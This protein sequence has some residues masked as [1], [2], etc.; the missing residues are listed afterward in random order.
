MTMPQCPACG[1]ALSELICSGCE[2]A[3]RDCDCENLNALD[4]DADLLKVPKNT[5]LEGRLGR[6]P[7]RRR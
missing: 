6:H 2:K 3:W 7:P 1:R 5:E 4:V